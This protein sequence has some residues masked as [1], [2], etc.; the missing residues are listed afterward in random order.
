MYKKVIIM[1]MTQYIND[2]LVYKWFRK[3][4]ALSAYGSSVI[5]IEVIT[6]L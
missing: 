5:Q 1:I 4:K 3:H 6:L 2:M